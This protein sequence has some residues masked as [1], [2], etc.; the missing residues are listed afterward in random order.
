M[1]ILGSSSNA[2]CLLSSGSSLSHP[3]L[4]ARA[5]RGEF[6]P[7]SCR[8]LQQS[9]K[10][11]GLNWG[12]DN[13]R[14]QEEE[15]GALTSD[16]Q[17]FSSTSIRRRRYCSFLAPCCCSSAPTEASVS[18]GATII[19]LPCLPFSPAEVFVP[20]ST[21]TLH[22]YEA[23]FLALLDEVIA[24]G[25]N[26]L[27]HI[28]VQPVQGDNPG[29]ASFVANYGCLAH[30]ESVRRLD[31]GALVTIRGIGRLKMVSLTQVEPFIKSTVVP[32]TDDYPEDRESL[33]VSVEALRK[34]LSEVQQLQIK[35]KTART[36]LLQTPLEGALQWAE[37][38]EPD[39]QIQAFVPGRE[40]RFS[41]A[42]LQP[43]SG[44]SPGELHKL[45]QE[46]LKAME[47]MDTEVR[48]VNVTKY[49]EQSR[50]SLAAKVAL[51]S[52]QF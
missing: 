12:S 45:L 6:L 49:A 32:V 5:C 33:S 18:N 22:L 17:Q 25:N 10:L 16:R 29:V 8:Q 24:A 44:A 40:E 52:L 48:L 28:V 31:I 21:K 13:R 14:Q 9:H 1:A 47:T 50:A 7:L 11:L 35:I 2:R 19:E 34:T 23:R 39:Q 26:L 4:C 51:Q 20:S 27:A 36:E 46:R 41:Y 38:G 43:V 42:A 15:R 30:I 3:L 37:K